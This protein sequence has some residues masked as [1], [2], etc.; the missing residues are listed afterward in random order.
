MLH[1]SKLGWFTGCQFS[2]SVSRFKLAKAQVHES[3]G[4]G[5]TFTRDRTQSQL[6]HFFMEGS[7]RC[8]DNVVVDL[9]SVETEPPL[10]CDTRPCSCTEASTREAIVFVVL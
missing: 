2:L 6:S 9:D 10:A 5:G 8:S 4:D 7:T 3:Q 1:E